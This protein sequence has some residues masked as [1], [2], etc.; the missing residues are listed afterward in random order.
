MLPFNGAPLTAD[1]EGA[2]EAHAQKLKIAVYVTCTDGEH[3]ELEE[4]SRQ[5]SAPGVLEAVLFPLTL[6]R[7]L[8][9]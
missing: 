2:G 7:L 6:R 5:R 3:V 8:F 1:I 4:V 9:V